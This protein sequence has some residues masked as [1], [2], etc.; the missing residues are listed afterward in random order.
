MT[1][2]WILLSFMIPVAIVIGIIV[3]IVKLATKNNNGVSSSTTSKNKKD[4]EL[5]LK[6]IYTYLIL[7]ST[8][9][10][11]IGGSVGVFM[12]IADYV[13]PPSYIQSY[14]SFK[15]NQYD[16]IRQGN[17]SGV[18]N[19]DQSSQPEYNYTEMDKD[20]RYEYD[21]MKKEEIEK[22]KGNALGMI[23]KSFGWIIIPLPLFIYFQR[24]RNRETNS[25]LEDED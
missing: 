6:S 15:E 18:Y 1:V 11:S 9:M 3:L 16:R 25:L 4:G 24:Q 2:I 8:L 7:F 23:I 19:P 10:M 12:G 14:D 5:M 17:T 13:S 20:I 22:S 21:I